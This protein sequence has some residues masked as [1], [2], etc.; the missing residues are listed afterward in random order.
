SFLKA[1][2]YYADRITTV[3]PTYAREITT[4]AEGGGFEGLL[5][6]RAGELSGILN[7][8]DEREWDPA[9]DPHLTAHYG[10]R[11]LD[12]K[13]EAQRD[14]R[15]AL[16]LRASTSAP[17]FGV[18]SR[19]AWQKGLDLLVRA[20]PHLLSRG[21]DLAVLGAGDAGLSA[22]LAGLAAAHPGRVAFVD[23][24]DERLAHRIQAGA[25]H[26]VV[27]SRSEPCGLVQLYALR[28]GS[29]PVVRR[30]G[31]LAD[32][33]VDATPEALAAGRATGFVFEDASV[34]ALTRALDRAFDLHAA[35]DTLTELRR[36][37]MRSSF[38]WRHAAAEYAALYR[39]LLR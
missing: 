4:A 28:Y 27:P 31:G 19:L 6:A 21:G 17:L 1:A 23:G 36:A 29:P 12:G 2:L 25:D 35:P 33:V 39:S 26:V 13:R 3:S 34:E 7:G 8:I 5:A 15:R 16:G 38:G 10:L 30:T 32:T 18:V 14:L 37:G 22:E 20:T 11:S 9:T 24:Y